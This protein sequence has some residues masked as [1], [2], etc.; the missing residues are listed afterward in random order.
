MHG[1]AQNRA[2]AFEL[3][4]QAGELGNAAA[5]YNIGYAYYSGNGV[6]VDKRK[7]RYYYELAAMKGHAGARYSLG[8]VEDMKGNTERA[9][10][11]HMIAIRSGDIRSLEEI[12]HLYTDGHAS[13]Q[14][15]TTA[16]RA[17]Q[18]YLAEI[19]SDQRDKAAAAKDSYKYIE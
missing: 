19:K 4:R 7:A 17:Y 11:H 8:L 12:R 10:K 13:K 2:K 9:I 1:L 16:L 14:D 18:A 15:Y 5:Y 6:E 3:W